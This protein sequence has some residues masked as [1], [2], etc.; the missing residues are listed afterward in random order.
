MQNSTKE[1]S[2][3]S[4]LPFDEESYKTKGRNIMSSAQQQQNPASTPHSSSSSNTMAA[5]VGSSIS[6]LGQSLFH[7]LDKVSSRLVGEATASFFA[8]Q[9][10]SDGLAGESSPHR[11]AIPAPGLPMLRVMTEAS[12]FTDDD[13][14]DSDLESV[15]D[16]KTVRADNKAATWQERRIARLREDKRRLEWTR[17]EISPRKG[18]GAGAVEGEN[19]D[20]P[21]ISPSI[22]SVTP[23]RQARYRDRRAKTVLQE[24]NEDLDRSN[25]LP[26][27]PE[28]RKA[29]SMADVQI[30]GDDNEQIN[31][32]GKDNG[33]LCSLAFVPLETTENMQSVLADSSEETTKSE[34]T[35]STAV[36]AKE[37]VVI[38]GSDECATCNSDNP[39]TSSSDDGQKK[40]KRRLS[41]SKL[42]LAAV[43]LIVFGLVLILASVFRRSRTNSLRGT[44]SSD[45]LSM[46]SSSERT[47]PTASP[48]QTLYEPTVVVAALPEKGVPTASLSTREPTASPSKA[49]YP[50]AP[51]T[52]YPTSKQRE[53]QVESLGVTQEKSSNIFEINDDGSDDE[54]FSFYVIGRNPKLMRAELKSIE[55]GEFFVHLGDIFSA[56]DQD[57]NEKAYDT[58][59][60]LLR[61]AHL[62]VLVIPG[63]E[64]WIDC[65]NVKPKR[66]LNFWKNSFV[67]FEKNWKGKS[68]LPG[69]VQRSQNYPENFAFM[70]RGTLFIGINNVHDDDDENEFNMREKETK[71][72]IRSQVKTFESDPSLRSIVV[73]A[74]AHNSNDTFDWITQR[75]A[76]KDLQVQVVHIHQSYA[77]KSSSSNGS[78]IDVPIDDALPTKLT[79][80]NGKLLTRVQLDDK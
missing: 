12:T 71:I 54:S 64:D 26:Q 50:T 29:H 25:V 42:S 57:C 39:S 21:S 56:K 67:D 45:A 58:A 70:F 60:D 66:A 48:T 31:K 22:L 10:V 20:M 8:D 62:P 80:L 79:I 59:A 73:F 74:H 19:N 77:D 13:G 53:S 52:S 72:F 63:D 11:L 17:E 34:E 3:D 68:N 15:D 43:I 1:S 75:L 7:N 36:V 65:R 23:P 76:E 51:P 33:G 49:Y 69:L 38:A 46:P 40:K 47:N 28:L 35:K 16:D 55:D 30:C 37:A 14:R 4:P 41:L 5:K 44:A 6:D 61:K 32:D 24:K 18:A 9:S 27:I 2:D 78:F